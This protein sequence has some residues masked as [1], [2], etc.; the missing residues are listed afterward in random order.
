MVNEAQSVEN[1]LYNVPVQSLDVIDKSTFA[2]AA[3]PTPNM[4][5]THCLNSA[6]A[7]RMSHAQQVSS[8]ISPT[9]MDL[10]GN[11]FG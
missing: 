6:E 9:P 4:T 7:S 3:S 10:T 11:F 5:V 8:T 1:Q 2:S